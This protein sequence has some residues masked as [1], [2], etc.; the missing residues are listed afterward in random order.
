MK[1]SRILNSNT[2]TIPQVDDYEIFICALM[3]AFYMTI[4]AMAI[5]TAV[6]FRRSNISGDLP[7]VRISML[8]FSMGML[9][10]MFWTL[11]SVVQGFP[12]S[13]RRF[14]T[15]F[16]GN[17][18]YDILW[19]QDIAHSATILVLLFTARGGNVLDVFY[20]SKWFI[21]SKHVEDLTSKIVVSTSRERTS[22]S[23]HPVSSS[24]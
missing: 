24:T 9:N 22:T 20:P 18:Y 7:V 6:I 16:F 10:L 19:I 14:P 23:S 5:E 11:V 12:Y 2:D 8:C 21:S 1:S 4:V 17:N 3:V 13:D 15:W